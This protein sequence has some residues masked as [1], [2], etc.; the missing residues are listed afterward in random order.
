M[1]SMG[2]C[3]ESA[4]FEGEDIR[5]T[6]RYSIDKMQEL[7]KYCSDL[8]ISIIPEIEI[9]AHASYLLQRHP[10]FMCDCD[11]ENRSSW[12]ICAG[13]EAVAVYEFYYKLIDEIC[14]IFPGEYMHV[15]G[16]ELYFGDFPEWNNL[17]HW[18]ICSVCAKR[19]QEEN[20]TELCEL[21]CYMMNRINEK[22]KSCGRKMIIWNDEIDISKD[23]S[24]SRDIIIEYWRI[25]NENRGPRKG[26]SF[27]EF[28]KKGFKVINANFE[29]SYIN[30][31]PYANPEKMASYSYKSYLENDKCQKHQKSSEYCKFT[32]SGNN[33]VPGNIR[34]DG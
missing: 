4:V 19:M 9:P 17:C 30:M 11:I 33:H 5:E 3:Y 8:G 28:L 22:I 20:I 29:K 23:I 15:G 2:I 26:C 32:K 25:S 7:V 21:Y 27:N 14:N 12:D 10:E 1:D 13:N 6:K 16:D 34:N 18:D 31:E 24:L